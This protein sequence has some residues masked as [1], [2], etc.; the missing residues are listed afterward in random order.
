MIKISRDNLY[1]LSRALPFGL[2]L[3]DSLI[4]LMLIHANLLPLYIVYVVIVSG[5]FFIARA[6]R[7]FLLKDV[8]LTKENKIVYMDGQI[9]IEFE[10]SEIRE[11]RTTFGI[12]EIEVSNLDRKLYCIIGSSE[13]LKYL[14]PISAL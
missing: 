10:Q 2:I 1:L 7:L 6:W 13:N 4:L 9:K 14:A 8:Y 3:I 5:Q 12:S 11:L